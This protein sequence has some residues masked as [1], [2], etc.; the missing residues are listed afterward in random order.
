MRKTILKIGYY[1]QKFFDISW[2]YCIQ[3]VWFVAFLP[4]AIFALWATN[5]NRN[6]KGD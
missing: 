1:Y 5:P 3:Y 6:Q 2:K 4:L